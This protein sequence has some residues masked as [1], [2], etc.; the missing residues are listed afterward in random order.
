MLANYNSVKSAY[1]QLTSEQQSS[2]TNYSKVTSGITQLEAA[3][4]PYN[5]RDMIAALP[6]QADVTLTD[7]SAVNAARAAY[8]NLTD[9]QKALVGEIT[10]HTEAESVITTLANQ[11]KQTDFTGDKG[12]ASNSFFEVT[13]STAKNSSFEVKGYGTFNRG[14]KM[15]SNTNIKFTIQSKMTLTLYVDAA[16]K[17]VNC[18]GSATDV[19]ATDASGNYV[20]TITLEAGTYTLTKADSVNLYYAVLS[21]AT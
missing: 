21:P 14:V 12:T 7:A 15:E 17:K 6:A 2:V 11:T 5:V 16:G 20:I 19:S 1:D 13:G 4:A 18:N 3:L 10:K 8:D 9:A